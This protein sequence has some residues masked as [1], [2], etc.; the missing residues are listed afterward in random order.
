L[1]KRIGIKLRKNKKTAVIRLIIRLCCEK[2]FAVGPHRDK[3]LQDE[4]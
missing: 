4:W 3:C 2:C 1:R